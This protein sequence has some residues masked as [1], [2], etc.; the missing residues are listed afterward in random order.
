MLCCCRVHDGKPSSLSADVPL[1]RVLEVTFSS[2]SSGTKQR[3][4]EE[5]KEDVRGL[6]LT[7]CLLSREAHIY[8]E[9]V[10]H[11]LSKA[12]L[13]CMINTLLRSVYV[14][15]VG[16]PQEGLQASLSLFNPS[17]ERASLL[18]FAAEVITATSTLTAENLHLLL[19]R[20][21]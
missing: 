1:R 17:C 19:S 15:A 20:L 9:L 10:L 12:S 6:I 2:V 16:K 5:K 7:D 3:K 13:R 18:G 8:L 21:R 11:P 4:K 14:L